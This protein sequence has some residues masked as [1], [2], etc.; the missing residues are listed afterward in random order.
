VLHPRRL[1]LF[2][3]CVPPA[4]QSPCSQHLQSNAANKPTPFSLSHSL[5]LS[6]QPSL[7]SLDHTH[8]P[9]RHDCCQ[10]QHLVQPPSASSSITRLA[11]VVVRSQRA[12]NESA[13]VSIS[14]RC[15]CGLS[16]GTL[17]RHGVRDV[18]AAG[19]ALPA[20]CA[21]TRTA[22]QTSSSQGRGGSVAGARGG[23][24]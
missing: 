20:A 24:A 1:P 23:P 13:P 15:V 17:V 14:E 11:R 8:S 21:C 2:G 12:G 10:Q 19:G 3:P 16:T 4:A 7:S 5:R 9:P 6:P 22:Q 18:S